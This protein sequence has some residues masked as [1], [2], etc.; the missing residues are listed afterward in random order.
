MDEWMGKFRWVGAWMD[1][2]G[3]NNSGYM[4][5]WVNFGGWVDI[6]FDG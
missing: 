1:G 6:S 2:D 5:G 4:D 3:W